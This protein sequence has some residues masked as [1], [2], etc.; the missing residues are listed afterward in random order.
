[1]AEIITIS[2]ISHNQAELVKKLLDDIN[3]H[4]DPKNIFV[5]LTNNLPEK[6]LFNGNDYLFEIKIVTNKSPK[7]FGANHN[8]AFHHRRGNWFCVMNPDIRLHSNPFPTLIGE[9]LNYK[10]GIISPAV[11]S[12]IGR[13]EDN[14]RFFPTPLSLFLKILSNNK[15]SSNYQLGDEVFFSDWVAGM[16]MLFPSQFFV[17]LNGFDEGFYLYYED[18]DICVRTWKA[19]REVI[20]CPKVS[21]IHDAQRDSRRILR[22]A[23]WHLR[24]LIRYFTK[25]FGRLPK[26]KAIKTRSNKAA[27][28]NTKGQ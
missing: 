27:I 28:L 18:V 9:L 5:I 8:A 15:N 14:A 17:D 11:Q 20:V 19:G 16:F 6:N 4:C 12:P 25:Y 24:S 13:I 2:I 23:I 26:S 3:Q 1:M 10:T 7:G 21:V 22:Y